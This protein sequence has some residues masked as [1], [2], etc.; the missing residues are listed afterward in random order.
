MTHTAKCQECSWE[1]QGERA[2]KEAQLHLEEHPDHHAF[3]TD[4]K[5]FS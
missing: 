1:Y 3:S 4:T 2:Y 5:G